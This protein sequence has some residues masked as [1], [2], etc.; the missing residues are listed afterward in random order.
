MVIMAKKRKLADLVKEETIRVEKSLDLKNNSTSTTEVTNSQT[1]ATS[2]LQTNELTNSQTSATSELQTNE[3]TNS[4]ASATSELQTN[5]LTNSQTS[6]TSELQA[7]ELT[8]SQTPAISKLPTAELT[9]SRLSE[10][11]FS[12][13]YLQEKK[14]LTLERT[15]KTTK[16]KIKSSNKKRDIVESEQLPKYLNFARKEARL[17]EDQLDRLTVLSRKLNRSRRGQGER[18]T[19]NTLIRLAIDLLFEREQELIGTTEEELEIALG[20]LKTKKKQ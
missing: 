14:P 12:N 2:E 7:A 8:N 5:E 13:D 10:S 16:H 20:L 9:D 19:E 11:L 6:A 17:R 18:I 15:R 3:L 4:Q 1:L